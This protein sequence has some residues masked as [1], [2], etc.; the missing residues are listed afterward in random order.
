MMTP[1]LTIQMFSI[2]ITIIIEFASICTSI[3]LIFKD[4][5]YELDLPIGFGIGMTILLIFVSILNSGW[6]IM[7]W[8]ITKSIYKNIKNEFINQN[9]NGMDQPPAYVLS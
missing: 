5:Y 9:R 2:V 8:I 7:S 3:V 4:F 1:W 6:E